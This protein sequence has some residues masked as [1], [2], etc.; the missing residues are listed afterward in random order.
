[1]PGLPPSEIIYADKGRKLLILKKMSGK[2]MVYYLL[3]AI[4][5]AGAAYF[6]FRWLDW[7]FLLPLLLAVAA[8]FFFWKG[9]A[10]SKKK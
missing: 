3:G 5:L 7:K 10:K 6:F 4:A 2:G 1:M 8:V 9:S